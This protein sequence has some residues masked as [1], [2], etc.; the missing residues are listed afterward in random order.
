MEGGEFC[1]LRRRVVFPSLGLL[2]FS[3]VLRCF[4]PLVGPL[5]ALL[6]FCA[7]WETKFTDQ[8]GDGVCAY[9]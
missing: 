1:A 9:G 4:S 6:R 3:R 8:S 2:F 7:P 5:G